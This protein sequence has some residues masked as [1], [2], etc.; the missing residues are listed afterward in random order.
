MRGVSMKTT[1]YSLLR[2]VPVEKP[3]RLLRV[4][5]SRSYSVSYTLTPFT[6]A[7][8]R[9]ENQTRVF[10]ALVLGSRRS[11]LFVLVLHLEEV[12]EPDR[13]DQLLDDEDELLREETDMVGMCAPGGWR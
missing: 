3:L 11:R 7:G 5:S 12:R 10:T 9:P 2:V 4:S 13:E 1:S 6:L 8:F